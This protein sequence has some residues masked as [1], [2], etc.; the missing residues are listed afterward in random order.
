MDRLLEI[1]K[2]MDDT[3]DYENEKALIDDRLIDSIDVVALVGDLEDE[4][5]IEIEASEMVPENFNSMEGMRNM[6]ERLKDEQ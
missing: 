1:L 4:F 2:D 5:D 6:I 3:V